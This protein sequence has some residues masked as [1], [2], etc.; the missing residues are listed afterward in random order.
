MGES[1]TYRTLA[2]APDKASY[3]MVER[4]QTGR[5][6]PA[7]GWPGHSNPDG[8]VRGHTREARSSAATVVHTYRTP[9]V[10]VR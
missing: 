2:Q 10:Q 8:E 5:S 6:S 9:L 7:A 4:L 3:I 1:G